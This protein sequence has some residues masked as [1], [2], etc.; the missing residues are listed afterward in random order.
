MTRTERSHSLR[1][2]LKDRSEARNGMDSSV[3][4]GGAGG[5]NWGSLDQVHEIAALVNED[6]D[7]EEGEA[8]RKRPHH[9]CHQKPAPVRRMSS[10]TDEDREN[11]INVRKNAFKNKGGID[12]VEIARSSSA[13][14]GSPPK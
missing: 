9:S 8:T 1:A 2:L 3:P 13:V 4:K 10:L 5:H 6:A 12:L 14:S 7:F 11:A